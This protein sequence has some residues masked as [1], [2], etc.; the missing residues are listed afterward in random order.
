MKRVQLLDL[1]RSLCVWMMLV[2]HAVYDLTLFGVLHGSVVSHPATRAY[3]YLGAGGFVLLSGVCARWSRDPVLR[4]FK[5]FCCGL[6]VSVAT[7]AAGYPVAFGAL[8]LL[9]CCMILYGLERRRIEAWNGRMLA[10]A[11][12]FLFFVSGALTASMRIDIT[13]LYPLGLR[14][15]GFYSADYFP[16]LPWVFLFLLGTAVGRRIDARRDAPA[17]RR[18]Y[19]AALAFCGRHSLA[20]YLL[21]QPILYGICWLIWGK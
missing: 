12:L 4:G 7:T 17:L 11:C 2:Y 20:I 9:G 13:F 8:H 15:A 1:W 21:H 19:P 18:T 6:I 3:C 16:L 5:V 14:T 10:A